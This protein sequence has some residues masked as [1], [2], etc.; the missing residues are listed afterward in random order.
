MCKCN[1]F[2][3]SDLPPD[4]HNQNMGG[5]QSSQNVSRQDSPIQGS[6]R[7]SSASLDN[8]SILSRP[9]GSIDFGGER[10][11]ARRRRR[12]DRNDQFIE[13]H[14]LPSH[15]FPFVTAEIKCPVCNKRIGT[16]DIESHLLVCLAKP[17][18]SYNE[19]ILQTDSG[20]CIICFD[21]MVAGE[22]IARLPCLCIYHKKCLDEWFSRNRCCPAHPDQIPQEFTDPSS[23]S[24][25]SMQD[26]ESSSHNTETLGGDDTLQEEDTHLQPPTA[27]PEP[28]TEENEDHTSTL[29]ELE[30]IDDTETE[31]VGPNQSTGVEDEGET[32]DSPTS[33][34]QDTEEEVT[35]DDCSC[36]PVPTSDREV[37]QQKTIVHVD[38]GSIHGS[39]NLFD[40]DE[41]AQ[42]ASKIKTILVQESPRGRDFED[43]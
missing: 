9:S 32:V 14:S 34:N 29:N 41:I 39:P 43:T 15:L 5:R 3:H 8:G 16:N 6:S 33:V 27:M 19:D 20:E 18:V 17:R 23:S 13:A 10:P 37:R 4:H 22:H 40:E 31:V 11:V 1:R 28:E 42:L 24:A 25:P 36:T 12:R 26:Q 30:N 38:D 2:P 21:D 35:P 7:Y